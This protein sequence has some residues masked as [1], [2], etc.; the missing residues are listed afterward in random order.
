MCEEV[1]YSR[2]IQTI[3][4]KVNWINHVQGFI[5]NRFVF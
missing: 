4:L 2:L 5:S 1:Y 3:C